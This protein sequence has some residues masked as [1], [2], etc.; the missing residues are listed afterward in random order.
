MMKRINNAQRLQTADGM[1][2][3]GVIS[4]IGVVRRKCAP[5]QSPTRTRA[6]RE[7]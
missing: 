2:V 6:D 3:T 1:G 7:L 5:A 4:V